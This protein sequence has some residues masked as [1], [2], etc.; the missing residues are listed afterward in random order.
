MKTLEPS[1]LHALSSAILSDVMDSLGLVRRAMKPF[2]RPVDDGKVARSHEGEKEFLIGG[3]LVGGLG[4]LM[5]LIGFIRLRFGG[6]R[7]RYCSA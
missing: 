3:G 6:A 2:I 5:A 4:L 7:Q 1:Q